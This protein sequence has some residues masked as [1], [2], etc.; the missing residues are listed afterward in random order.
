MARKDDGSHRNAPALAWS[1]LLLRLFVGGMFLQSGIVRWQWL[2][3]DQMKR[4]LTTWTAGD[5][6]AAFSTYVPFLTKYI[7]PHAP[8]FTYLVVLGQIAVGALLILGLTTR[9]AAL[10]ALMMSM[11]FLLATWNKGYEWQGINEAFIAIELTL[12]LGGAGRFAGIDVPLARKHPNW[13]F[14]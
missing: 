3:T 10:P 5:T 9:L 6:P 8:V 12:L 11:N 13:P 4:L 2:G 14:W 1:L 7:I